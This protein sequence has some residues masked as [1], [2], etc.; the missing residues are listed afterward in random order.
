MAGGAEADRAGDPVDEGGRMSRTETQ[1]PVKLSI[2][3]TPNHLPVVRAATE[4][5]CR[6]IGFA[7]PQVTQ[8]V[9]SVDEALTN[10][11]RHAYGGAQDRPIEIELHALGPAE[12]G[13]V[14]RI[15]DH[16]GGVSP[17]Q[18]KPRDLDELRPGGLGVHIM[19][20][21]MDALEYQPAEGG[22]TMLVMVKRLRP[23]AGGHGP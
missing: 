16:G 8:V 2:F 3:S 15:R 22:G 17:Q 1:K 10:V 18:I 14:V 7:E 11:I 13:I 19:T 20:E 12:R 21:C 5:L 4:R 23:A 9:L 6:T